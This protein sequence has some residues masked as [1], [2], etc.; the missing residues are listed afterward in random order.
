[1]LVVELGTDLALES[2]PVP[3][4]LLCSLLRRR[5]KAKDRMQVKLSDVLSVIF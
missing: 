3:K 1:M 4:E 5:G 2:F